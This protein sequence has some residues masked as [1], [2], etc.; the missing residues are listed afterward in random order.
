MRKTSSFLVLAV[1]LGLAAV[2]AAGPGAGLGALAASQ[3]TELWGGPGA[4]GTG[5]LGALFDTVV[6]VTGPAPA[7]GAVEFLAHG[8][9]L[10]T[11]PFTVTANG[12][13]LVPAP[14]AVAQKGAFLYRVR[15]DAPVS[16]WSETFN[17]TASGRFGVSLSAATP[18]ELLG[19]GDEATG[20]G[21]EVS[22]STGPGHARTNAGVVCVQTSS[23]PCR[24]EVA[25]FS[26]GALVGSGTIDAAPGSAAQA[27]LAT[28]V[29]AA[30]GRAGLAL[31]LRLL[32]GQ[33]LPY[34]IRND[35]RTSDGT[36]IPLAVKRNAFSTAPTIVSFTA[37]PASGCAP[38]ETTFTWET[39]GATKVS[40]S[41][42]GND[43]PASGSVKATLNATDD[44]VLTATS[45]T[46]Q[47]AT[48]P[49]RI[50]ITPS[51]P[52]PTPAPATATIVTGGFITGILSAGTGPVTVEFVKRESTGST[53]TVQGNSWI[54][55]AGT[56]PGTDVVKITATGS[57][58]PASAEFT[59]HV[60]VPGAPI[61]LAFEAV[62]QAGCAPMTKVLL[63]WATENASGVIVNDDWEI[64]PANGGL[65]VD[66]T[67]TS[68]FTLRAL[69]L[70]GSETSQ[71]IT[72]PIDPQ[73]YVPIITP[74]IVTVVNG[75]QVNIDV[76]PASVPDLSG[77]RFF[78]VELQSAGNVRKNLAVPGRFVYT[79][80]KLTGIDTIRILWVNG[81]GIGYVDFIATVTAP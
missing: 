55:T 74:K 15:S 22:S 10:A 46:G 26:A 34:A 70:D 35:N 51:T 62:P 21:A 23:Q 75:Q 6:Y 43:L 49:L 68:V 4:R 77:V 25:L 16:A 58:A 7:A 76:D 24:V 8:Q 40:I 38:L 5:N 13:A 64:L 18:G 17:E 28:L 63:T 29:P 80:G 45:S 37:S 3:G 52:A 9:V 19:P 71:T 59:A 33:G 12:V 69:G 39:S 20:G 31:R 56:T 72:V 14:E 65:E 11:L 27:S 50:T 1:L 30:D 57:C 48:K 41:G 66:L 78:A 47:S 73:L 61:I 54:Y 32:S 42:V 60:V 36:V 53:F 44:Y 81:C 79:A 67:A 2:A